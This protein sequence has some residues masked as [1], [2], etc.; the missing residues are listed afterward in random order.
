ME[1]RGEVRG[2]H[3][4]RGVSGE[5]FA[6][7]DAIGLMRTLRKAPE[8]GEL[9]TIAAADPLNLVGILTPGARVPATAANR[10]LLR[11]G[12]PV[13]ALEGGQ[14]RRL[15]PDLDVPDLA[16]ERA[17][18]VGRLSAKLRPFYA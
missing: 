3:F 4:V 18:K 14:I 17:L 7:P 9:V 10:I 8:K 2:G 5:Q 1:A 13:A 11:D 6:L 15:D 16:V 12:V